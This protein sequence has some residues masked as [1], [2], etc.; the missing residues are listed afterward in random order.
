MERRF[1]IFLVLT[2]LLWGGF[3]AVRAFL[4]PQPPP[5]A[6]QP[7]KV[8]P[9]APAAARQDQQPA[10]APAAVDKPAPAA[11]PAEAVAARKG[12]L[13]SLLPNSGYA[14]LVTWDNHGAAIERVELNSPRYKSVEDFSGYLGHLDLTNPKE[15][16]AEVQVVGPG[17]PAALAPV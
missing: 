3:L 4:L 8:A 12:Q 7:A 9:A 1:A 14:M 17:T 5:V 2:V 13:G 10:E 11:A 15:G 16:G 6:K